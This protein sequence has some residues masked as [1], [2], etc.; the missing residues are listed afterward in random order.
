MN[1]DAL[2][3]LT[4]F[5]LTWSRPIEGQ[6][7]PQIVPNLLIK[8][9]ITA[10]LGSE[11]HFSLAISGCWAFTS[12][13]AM[14]VNYGRSL[15]AINFPNFFHGSFFSDVFVAI[16]SSSRRRQEKSGSNLKST[17]K[18]MRF[19]CFSSIQKQL[20]LAL[21]WFKYFLKISMKFTI[22]Q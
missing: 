16:F 3:I 7:T 8:A 6:S 21:S 19:W 11:V 4:K 12:A 5:S 14:M 22:Y 1:D 15:V 20:T 10:K 9:Q 13:V 2:D 17:S 18:T